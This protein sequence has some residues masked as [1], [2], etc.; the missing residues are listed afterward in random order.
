MYLNNLNIDVHPEVRNEK[1]KWNQLSN[2]VLCSWEAF[3][4]QIRHIENTTEKLKKVI[5]K[6]KREGLF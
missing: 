4:S 1:H 6:V 5:E 3:L 2:R